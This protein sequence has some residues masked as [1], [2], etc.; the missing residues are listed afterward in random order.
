MKGEIKMNCNNTYGKALKRID[1]NQQD[2]PKYICCLG[3]TG[4]Q[5][6][7]GPAGVAD[8]ITI[9]TVTTG[10]PG[11][12]ASVTDV[13]G[14][15]NHV[16]DFVIPRGSDGNS[17]DFCCFCTRQMLN[18]IQ[19]IIALYP[20]A[21]WAVSLDGGDII[22]GRPDTLTVGP[23]GEAGTLQIVDSQGISTQFV[24]I[25]SIDTITINNITYNDTITYL[26]AP[27]PLPTDCC[28]DCDTTI[29]SK[30]PIGTAGVLITTSTQTPT[31]GTIIRN[32]YG[33]VVLNDPNANNI[34]FVSSCRIDLV[35]ISNNPT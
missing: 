18:I 22:I 23:N 1:H 32:E 14:G 13:T 29:R 3:T 5:G 31:Q 20:N 24:S 33:M 34:S 7:Q 25:C 10:A 35:Y 11:T 27:D 19:Q 28:T 8:T 26:P 30:L 2:I 16:L 6:P 21:N 12:N 4:P 15:P 17:N 9:G